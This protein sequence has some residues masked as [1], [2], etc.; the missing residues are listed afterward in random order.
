MRAFLR[1]CTCIFLY[2]VTV[3]SMDKGKNKRTNQELV[4]SGLKARKLEGGY[5]SQE[6]QSYSANPQSYE[7]TSRIRNEDMKSGANKRYTAKEKVT[8]G[9]QHVENRSGKVGVKNEL[10]WCQLG[11]PKVD[12]RRCQNNV[13]PAAA[14]H[15]ERGLVEVRESW[16][17]HP[18]GNQ[19]KKWLYRN[20]VRRDGSRG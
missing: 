11:A 8:N 9:A 2:V 19:K 16:P 18:G 14:T 15:R 1:V 7:R 20:L 13:W 5:K 10:T 12:S 3:F 17:G 6:V 4:Y